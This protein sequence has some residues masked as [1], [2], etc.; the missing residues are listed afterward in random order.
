M[1]MGNAYL[2][3]FMFAVDKHAFQKAIAVIHLKWLNFLFWINKTLNIYIYRFSFE[4]SPLLIILS[5]RMK[6]ENVK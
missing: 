4:I 3:L 2:R 5:I 1:Q 6:K